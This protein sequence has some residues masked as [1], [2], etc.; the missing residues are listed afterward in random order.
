MTLPT[1]PTDNLYKFIA[2][3]GMVLLITSIVVI[4]VNSHDLILKILNT[5]KT[6]L[7][8]EEK[9][10][11]L[12][13]VMSLLQTSGSLEEIKI[14]KDT[15]SRYLVEFAEIGAEIE[16]DKFLS[17]EFKRNFVYLKVLLYIGSIFA[18]LGFLLWY[19]KLQRFLDLTVK[20]D[21]ESSHQ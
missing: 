18:V 6:I 4:N 1:P 15:F 11:Q 9:L 14:A 20:R 17:K 21:S 13:E 5:D 8:L 12:E 19:L 16:I 3:A 10:D 7:V 2:I